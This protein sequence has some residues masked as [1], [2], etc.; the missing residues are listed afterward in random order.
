MNKLRYLTVY[1]CSSNE[2]PSLRYRGVEVYKKG[3]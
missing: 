2:E 1:M 3:G